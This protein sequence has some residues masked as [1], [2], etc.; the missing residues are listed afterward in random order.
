MLTSVSFHCKSLTHSALGNKVLHWRENNTLIFISV[1]AVLATAS[2]KSKHSRPNDLFVF[3]IHF[4][5]TLQIDAFP[6]SSTC[7]PPLLPAPE[8]LIPT[9]RRAHNEVPNKPPLYCKWEIWLCGVIINNRL[10]MLGRI[11]QKRNKYLMEAIHQG[12]GASSYSHYIICALTFRAWLLLC[13][14][15]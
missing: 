3:T 5:L 9:W 2:A 6:I 14:P 12:R 15:L 1:P 4:I 7:D 10:E 13:L 8:L 11:N